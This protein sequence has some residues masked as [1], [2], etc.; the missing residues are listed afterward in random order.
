VSDLPAAQY[1]PQKTGELSAAAL[2]VLDVDNLH[3]S[4]G[5]V[6]AVAGASF[7]VREGTI[8]GLIGPNGAGKSTVMSVIGGQLSPTSGRILFRGTDISGQQPHRI[9]GR[10]IIRTF[11]TANLFGRMTV[12]ENLLVGAPAWHGESVT[13]AFLGKW[14]WRAGEQQLVEQARE[15]IRRFRMDHIEREYAANLSGGQKRIVEIMR[16]LMA[17]PQ[18]LLLD[19][20]M[21]GVNPTLAGE[22]AGHLAELRS[23]GITML[24]VEHELAFVERLC[25][26]VIVMAQGRV[27]AQGSM[28]DLRANREVVNAYLAG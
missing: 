9:A 8:T 14:R 20:P 1:R 16:A 11:Q 17:Q 15:L 5:G 18:L 3:R 25:D 12:I 19:E 10:G 4:F 2:P 13:D 21:A 24:M 23:E 27:L 7:A 28:S 6:Q 26:P 22:I